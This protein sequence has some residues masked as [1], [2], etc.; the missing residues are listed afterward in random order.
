[1]FYDPSVRNAFLWKT[2]NWNRHL[3]IVHKGSKNS[4]NI[5][6]GNDK[7]ND[8]TETGTESQ[9]QS[10]KTSTSASNEFDSAAS[11]TETT[12]P[13]T[14]AGNKKPTQNISVVNLVENVEM[15]DI[16]QTNQ[17]VEFEDNS[18]ER[19]KENPEDNVLIPN[20]SKTSEP[21]GEASKMASSITRIVSYSDSS[22]DE[23]DNTTER[24]GKI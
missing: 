22:D 12:E 4:K 7:A 13:S 3:T 9:I 16:Q 20:C 8:G 5:R 14:T 15:S 11:G 21:P 23:A 19:P 2:T 24:S 17:S 10:K 18:G 1:M 6:K